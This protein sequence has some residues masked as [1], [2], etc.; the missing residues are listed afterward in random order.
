MLRDMLVTPEQ[1]RVSFSFN[2][3][4]TTEPQ[5]SCYINQ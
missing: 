1:L 3:E 2:H 4:T 5:E